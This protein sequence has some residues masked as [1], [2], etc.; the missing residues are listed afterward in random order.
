MD[1]FAQQDKTRRKTKLLVF[2]FILAVAAI[3][4]AGYFV[5]V[6]IFSAAQAH[7]HQYYGEQPQLVLWNPQLFLGV[8]VGVLAVIIIGS[9]YKT[10]E[11]SGGGGSVATLMGGRLVNPNTT[12]PDER[13]LLNVVEEMAI[14]SGVPVPQV[15][16]LD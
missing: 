10:N 14:A 11:L 12:N 5:G 6:V 8:T 13:K 1:F 4:L 2:Y 9:A 7:H 15:Y 3:I 16:V